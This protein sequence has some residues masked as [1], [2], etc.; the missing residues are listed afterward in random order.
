MFKVLNYMAYLILFSIFGVFLY[1]LKVLHREQATMVDLH[2]HNH[3]HVY[4]PNN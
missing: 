1:E 2:Q 4:H 3:N